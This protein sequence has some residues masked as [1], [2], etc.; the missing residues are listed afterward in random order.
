MPMLEGSASYDLLLFVY[1]IF[2]EK[3]PFSLA[4]KTIENYVSVV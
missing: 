2:Q 4:R 1:H 3:R